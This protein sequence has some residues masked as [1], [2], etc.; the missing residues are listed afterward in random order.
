[1]IVGFLV[2]FVVFTHCIVLRRIGGRSS[3]SSSSDGFLFAAASAAQGKAE[4]RKARQKTAAAF[5]FGRFL[6]SDWWKCLRLHFI[7]VVNVVVV[8]V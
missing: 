5:R 3:S 2:G 7:I 8:V 4:P 1:M 6:R